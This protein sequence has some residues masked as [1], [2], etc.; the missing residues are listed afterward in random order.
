MAWEYNG[1]TEDVIRQIEFPKMGA[2]QNHSKLDHDLV[3]KP[4][5]TWGSTILGKLHMMD[6]NKCIYIYIS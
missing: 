6:I 3:L 2:P 5:V 4:M 1:I